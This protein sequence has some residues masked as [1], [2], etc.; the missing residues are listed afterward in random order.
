MIC[1]G[2]ACYVLCDFEMMIADDLD[3]RDSIV[4]IDMILEEVLM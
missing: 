3:S 1:R 4:T 2:A